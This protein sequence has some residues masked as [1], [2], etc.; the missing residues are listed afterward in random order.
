MDKYYAILGVN[1]EASEVEIREA[2]RDLV[3]VWHPDRYG[4]DPKLQVKAQERL[5]EINEAFERLKAAEFKYSKIPDHSRY[6]RPT[7]PTKPPPNEEKRQGD[8]SQAR[9]EP[10][11]SSMPPRSAPESPAVG[12]KIL[13]RWVQRF[14]TPSFLLAIVLFF[15]GIGLLCW[16]LLSNKTISASKAIEPLSHEAVPETGA[17]S[18]TATN[19]QQQ[20][21]AL[22]PYQQTPAF[23]TSQQ[24]PVPYQPI[25]SSD[26]N[27]FVQTWVDK[28]SI[29]INEKSTL[30]YSLH[31]RYDTRYEGFDKEPNLRGFQVEEF[32]LD[33]NVPRETVTVNGKRYVKA[34]IKKMFISPIYGGDFV[35]DTGS[36][37]VDLRD[38]PTSGPYQNR[39]VYPSPVTIHVENPSGETKAESLM[40]F[41]KQHGFIAQSKGVIS[42]KPALIFLL[43]ISGSMLAEDIPPQNRIELAKRFIAQFLQGESNAAIGLKCFAKEVITIS[44]LTTTFTEVKNTL[45]EV[46][47]GMLPDG[48]AIGDAIFEATKELANYNGRQKTIILISDGK[49]NS[50]KLDA[51]TGLDFA[52]NEHIT[53]YTIAIG[54]KGTVSFPVDDPQFGKRYINADVG[55]DDAT[56]QEIAQTTGGRSY[57]LQNEMMLANIFSQIQGRVVGAEL[58]SVTNQTKGAQSD[59]KNKA[60]PL[61]SVSKSSFSFSR[62]LAAMIVAILLIGVSL[63]LWVSTWLRNKRMEKRDISKK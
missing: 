52:E 45:K 28:T 51:L 25:N 57:I 32:P 38:K 21:S 46:K 60:M 31:T 3:K 50:G 12:D 54:K 37:K 19:H 47:V 41:M 30:T 58:P 55:V 9:P 48:T 39:L 10:P 59:T 63:F 15:C 40:K 2:Y 44:P 61:S 17:V 14:K 27:I 43:D 5:K 56:M 23:Q 34:D 11:K 18:A 1:H 4:H 29:K 36:V 62:N 13:E 49:N 33:K 8:P 24:A 6:K 20:A 53:I 7:G 42:D 22:Q 26:N 35:I 16:I